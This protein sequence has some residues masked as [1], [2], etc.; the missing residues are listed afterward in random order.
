MP[1]NRLPVYL[2]IDTSGSMSG[3]PIAAVNQGVSRLID[4]LR[5]DDPAAQSVWISAVSYTPLTQ[6]TILLV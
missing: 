1:S 3:A 5:N 2:L 6:P 4:S